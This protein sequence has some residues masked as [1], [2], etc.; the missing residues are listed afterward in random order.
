MTKDSILYL[1]FSP[2]MIPVPSSFPAGGDKCKGISLAASQNKHW[3]EA[4]REAGSGELVIVSD[5]WKLSSDLVEGRD[6]DSFLQ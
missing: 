6:F 1:M 3:T 2:S 4:H 5:D